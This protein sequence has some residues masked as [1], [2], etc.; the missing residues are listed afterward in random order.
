MNNIMDYVAVDITRGVLYL[1]IGGID[2]DI[3]FSLY[4][5]KKRVTFKILIV[6]K[7]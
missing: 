5:R 2:L 4:I 1:F 6:E 7:K 3:E